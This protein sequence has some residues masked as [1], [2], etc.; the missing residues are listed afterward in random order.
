MKNR[1][2]Y[3]PLTNGALTT[4]GLHIASARREVGWTAQ[5]LAA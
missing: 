5:D 4:F 3:Q 1:H 2:A